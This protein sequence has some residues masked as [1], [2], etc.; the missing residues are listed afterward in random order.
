MV[1]RP[2]ASAHNSIYCEGAGSC[3]WKKGQRGGASSIT[4][5]KLESN[6]NH[7]QLLMKDPAMHTILAG[8]TQLSPQ[9]YVCVYY[10][11]GSNDPDKY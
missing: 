10:N 4:K 9:R 5:P 2:A 8:R 7:K 3:M 6:N 1:V 11:G